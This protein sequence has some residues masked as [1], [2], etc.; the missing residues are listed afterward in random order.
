MAL[1]SNIL[2]VMM[3]FISHVIF[4]DINFGNN[5]NQSPIDFDITLNFRMLKPFMKFVLHRLQLKKILFISYYILQLKRNIETLNSLLRHCL[6]TYM[7]SS[8]FHEINILDLN[9]CGMKNFYVNFWASRR[10]ILN[11]DRI[12]TTVIAKHTITIV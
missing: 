12:F 7:Q 2:H 9:V 1:K 3:L 10:C 5:Q 11:A 6:E 4:K 8:K